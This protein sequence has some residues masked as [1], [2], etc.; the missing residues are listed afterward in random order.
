MAK[1]VTVKIEIEDEKVRGMLE[2]IRRKV[3]DPKRFG[4]WRRLTFLLFMSWIAE[5]FRLQ[6]ARRGHR[7][8]KKLNPKYRQWKIAHRKSGR[9]LIDTGHLQAS[10]V[11]G[12]P[13]NVYK[14]ENLEMVFGTKVPYAVHH[15]SPK[16]P[17]RPPKREIVFI[18][19]QDR[20]EIDDV[21]K[22]WIVEV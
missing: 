12:A 6:G 13:D 1:G 8:W 5:T 11:V 19:R 3:K 7:A 15:Q 9:A 14:E 4:L 18:T 22:K 20:K 21:V 2:R 17:G 10:F 16:I